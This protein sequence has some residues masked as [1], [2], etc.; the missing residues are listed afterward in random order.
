MCVCWF[1]THAFGILAHVDTPLL[2]DL[3]NTIT[4]YYAA[5]WIVI[6]TQLGIPSGTLQGIQ[7]SFPSDAFHCCNMMLEKWLDIDCNATWGKVYKALECPGVIKTRANF[8]LNNGMYSAYSTYIV[9]YV[10]V[11]E[12]I[13][14]TGIAGQLNYVSSFHK[15]F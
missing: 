5:H 4:P 11:Y 1:I 2:K 8:Q 10:F 12:W 13:W 15:V 9:L 6:G 7:A 3:Q 14:K